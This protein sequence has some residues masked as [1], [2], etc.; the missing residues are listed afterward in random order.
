[1]QT[2]KPV[3]SGQPRE[4]KC[5]LLAGFVVYIQPNLLNRPPIFQQSPLLYYAFHRQTFY[6]T[7]LSDR[8]TKETVPVF[9]RVDSE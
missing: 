3:L 8:P 4:E 9:P 7:H 1:M 5:G 2:V 6:Q